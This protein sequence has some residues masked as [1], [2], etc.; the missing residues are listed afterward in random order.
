MTRNRSEEQTALVGGV[1][2][3]VD[4]RRVAGGVVRVRG[5]DAAE[6]GSV[7]PRRHA[8]Q[9]GNRAVDDGDTLLGGVHDDRGGR[10]AATTLD[11]GAVVGRGGACRG[12]DDAGGE[13]GNGRNLVTHELRLSEL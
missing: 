12:E 11:G 7:G 1:L 4:V 6:D 13:G 5:E 2:R 8:T 3:L 10:E 9:V